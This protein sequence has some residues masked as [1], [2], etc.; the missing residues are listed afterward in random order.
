[1]G[2]WKKFGSLW[3]HP[4]QVGVQRIDQV[5]VITEPRDVPSLDRVGF[6]GVV[7]RPH[8]VRYGYREMASTIVALSRVVTL[9]GDRNDF[10]AQCT[11]FD[12]SA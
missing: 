10:P 6:R 7:F 5:S 2:V 12:P 4:L 11:T 8:L 3:Q 9:V 1:M